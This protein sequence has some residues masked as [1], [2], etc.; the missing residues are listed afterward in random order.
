MSEST[1]RTLTLARELSEAIIK[2]EILEAVDRYYADDAQMQENLND[3][4]VGKP[5]II[6]HEKNFL[7]TVKEWK[8]TNFQAI[9]AEG[10]VAF[11]EY[12]F[13]FVNKEGQDMHYE[14]VSVQRWR[15][16]K[17]IHERFYYNAGG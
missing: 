4:T 2:G 12:S 16:G 5:A 17:I 9:A 15:D 6:E 10:D 14:Q 7:S 11:L 1:R 13:D 8:S 3:P